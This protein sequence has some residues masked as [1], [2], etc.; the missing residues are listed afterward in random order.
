MLD[1]SP[2]Q[3][4]AQLAAVRIGRL[5]MATPDGQP[6]AIPMPFCWHA[7]AL[8]L[9][10]P[11]KGRKGDILTQNPRVCFEIDWFTDTLDDYGS[12]LVEGLLQAVESLAEKAGAKAANDAKYDRLRQGFR[13][14][15]GRQTPLE[16]L[17]LQKIVVSK[18]TGRIRQPVPAASRHVVPV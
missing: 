2:R 14:G 15:H 11:M 3:I 5:C 6:Y 1:M 16:M 4:E 17:A 12:V 8:Y 18:M 13:P 9:R 7:G 10:I